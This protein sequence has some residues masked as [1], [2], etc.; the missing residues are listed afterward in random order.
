MQGKQFDFVQP[1]CG[2]REKNQSYRVDK[3]WVWFIDESEER[4]K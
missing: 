4:L 3:F 1:N 2:I